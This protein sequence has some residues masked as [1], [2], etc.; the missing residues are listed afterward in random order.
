MTTPF[1]EEQKRKHVEKMEGS[2]KKTLERF[3]Q[4][5][6]GRV[7]RVNWKKLIKANERFREPKG[8]TEET[9]E[10][11]FYYLNIKNI[12]CSE[13]S[14]FFPLGN[15]MDLG[16]STGGIKYHFE[17]ESDAK[18]YTEVKFAGAQYPVYIA[19]MGRKII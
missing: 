6:S 18:S 4:I 13:Y 11:I 3:V 15:G 17:F 7:K 10:E 8:I 9:L 2:E 19:R 12:L 1:I 5:E 14:G 16:P